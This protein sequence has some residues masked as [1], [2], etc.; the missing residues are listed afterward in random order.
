MS[1]YYLNIKGGLT[2][3]DLLNELASDKTVTKI[4]NSNLFKEEVT[5]KISA[6]DPSIDS[7][8]R[9]KLTQAITAL[10]PKLDVKFYGI[11]SL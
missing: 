10:I 8:V 5:S 4:E 2:A 3:T 6:N 1:V 7:F 11:E 9:E